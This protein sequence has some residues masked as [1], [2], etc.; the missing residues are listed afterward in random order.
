MAPVSTQS[1]SIVEAQSALEASPIYDLRGLQVDE[2]DGTLTISGRVSSFY[3]KQLAQE[4]VRIVS[5][6][7]KLANDVVVY[8][9]APVCHF[10]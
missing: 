2:H 7:L 3:H 5:G 6:D 4:I 10:E 1:N 9:D 8:E